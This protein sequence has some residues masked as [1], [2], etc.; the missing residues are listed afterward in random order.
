MAKSKATNVEENINIY[1]LKCQDLE[2]IEKNNMKEH[3]KREQEVLQ[4]LNHPFIIKFYGAVNDTK[5]KY[6][7]LELLQGGELFRLLMEKHS[8]PESWSRFYAGAVLSAFAE[9]HSKNF[10]YRDLKPENLVLDSKGYPKIVDFG[11]AKR[12][13]GGKTWTLCGT[14]DYMPPE[15]ILNEGHDSAADYWSVG[16]LLYEFSTGSPPFTSEYPMDVYKNILSGNVVM[17]A[18]FSHELRDLIKKLLNPRQATRIGRTYGGTKSIMEQDWFA[19]LNFEDLLEKKIE[20]PFVPELT[21]END[22]KYFYDY[23]EIDAQ[24][25][26]SVKLSW[27]NLQFIH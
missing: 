14:P 2:L 12:L 15:I 22:M 11:L 4:E 23:S 8:F 26:V 7:L 17:P 24:K 27:F 9:I 6:F 13:E 3:I 16:I 18:F 5:Y 20:P 10:V 1:V 21:D 25:E 19:E